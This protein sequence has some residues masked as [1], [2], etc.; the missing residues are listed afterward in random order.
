MFPRDT[1]VM[2]SI[3]RFETTV[4]IVNKKNDEN[5][6]IDL[7]PYDLLCAEVFHA[8]IAVAK[9]RSIPA[10]RNVKNKIFKGREKW[11]RTQ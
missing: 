7:W 9:L 10:D 11:I 1:T 8:E 2:S 6:S 3:K 5:E 4:E